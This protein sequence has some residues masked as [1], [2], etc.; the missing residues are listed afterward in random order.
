MALYATALLVV[1]C[2]MT[3]CSNSKNGNAAAASGTPAG[4]PTS[5]AGT[6]PAPAFPTGLTWF[7]V[8]HPLKLSDPNGK[9]VGAHAGEGVYPLFHPII[10]SLIS[11]FAAKGEINKAAL[12]LSLNNTTPSTVLSYPGAVLADPQGNRLFIADSS[13]NRILI[14]DLSGKLEQA[15][16]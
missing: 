3:A 9:L 8:D 5:W 1:I 6:T 14:S 11:E 10:S 16:G 2:A 12:P 7:N 4:T 13:H 15:I